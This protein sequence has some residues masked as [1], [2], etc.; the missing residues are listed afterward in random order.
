MVKL[1]NQAPVT[2]EV[3]RKVI[4]DAFIE[5]GED[6]SAQEIAARIGC[7]VQRVRKILNTNETYPDGILITERFKTS[8]VKVQVYGPTRQTLRDMIRKGL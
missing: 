2:S 7:N 3:V 5:T 8:A 1:T 6:Q 4:I